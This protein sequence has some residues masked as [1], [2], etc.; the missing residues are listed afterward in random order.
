MSFLFIYHQQYFTVI[1][2]NKKFLLK[3]VYYKLL[4]Y[5]TVLW[6]RH[7]VCELKKTFY[8][9]VFIKKCVFNDDYPIYIDYLLK[10]YQNIFFII[11][12]LFTVLKK[13]Q[14]YS[15]SSQA[16]VHNV[17]NIFYELLCFAVRPVF[18]LN[19]NSFFQTSSLFCKLTL[20]G[21]KR[22]YH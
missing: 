11:I 1:N 6:C 13:F 19:S 20:K 2:Y 22:I 9:N 8:R 16:H 14:I 4:K 21:R 7:E 5:S 17:H 18:T 3:S 12:Y 10:E 15:V